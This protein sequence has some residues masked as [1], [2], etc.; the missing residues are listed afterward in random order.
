M[1]LREYE[2]DGFKVIEFTSDGKT[3]SAIVS[4]KIIDSDEIASDTIETTPV[5]TVEEMQAQTLLITELLLIYK[6]LEMGV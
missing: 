2:E 4:E 5:P 3:A 6:E 1:V